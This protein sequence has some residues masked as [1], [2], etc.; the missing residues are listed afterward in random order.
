MGETR[1]G[2]RRKGC[3]RLPHGLADTSAEALGI[4]RAVVERN[5]SITLALLSGAI[6]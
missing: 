6:V 5:L 4:C 1:I 3:L 2:W